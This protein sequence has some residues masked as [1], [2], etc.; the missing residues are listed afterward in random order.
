MTFKTGDVVKR[1]GDDCGGIVT[2][3]T[4]VVY[5]IDDGNVYLSGHS[6]SYSPCYFDLVQPI[7]PNPP[8]VHAELIK[9][10]ADG[11]E[12]EFKNMHDEWKDTGPPIWYC[13]MDYRIK[14]AKSARDEQIEEL[15]RQA[16]NL[17]TEIANLKESN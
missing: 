17:A 7:Y 2:G 5:D 12:I 16:L 15:E 1:I 14:P 10:W 9:A 11:A 3:E 6:G 8:H 13:D 4:Y